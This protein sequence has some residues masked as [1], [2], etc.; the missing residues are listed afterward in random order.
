MAAHSRF[1][2]PF[3][4]LNHQHREVQ[5]PLLEIVLPSVHLLCCTF[6]PATFPTVSH[7]A[8]SLTH[9]AGVVHLRH[10]RW[11]HSTSHHRGKSIDARRFTHEHSVSPA[12]IHNIPS[13]RIDFGRSMF[14][15]PFKVG[16]SSFNVERSLPH[17]KLEVRCSMFRVQCP[18]T[19]P[20][21]LY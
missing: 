9:R 16:S 12:H 20:E 4:G 19:C 14:P 8:K 1:R 6:L 7:P 21:H 10:T 18:T 13:A 15:P 5:Q 17:S 11:C 2:Q 3:H